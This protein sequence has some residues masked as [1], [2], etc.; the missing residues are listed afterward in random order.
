MIAV[1]A[2]RPQSPV[3]D[4]ASFKMTRAQM[5]E[6]LTNY[7]YSENK[8]FH[9]LSYYIVEI[10]ILNEYFI[11]RNL[12]VLYVWFQGY[13]LKRSFYRITNDD[14]KNLYQ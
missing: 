3:F 9:N 5:Y 10:A 13:Q 2:V 14:A 12:M 1:F 4:E 7:V 11:L 6:H 8:V